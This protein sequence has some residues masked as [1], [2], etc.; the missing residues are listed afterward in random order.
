MEDVFDIAGRPPSGWMHA[1]F[2]GGPY[3]DDVGRCI[4]GPPAPEVLKVPLPEGGEHVYRLWNVGSWLDPNDPIAVYNLDVPP[5][6]PGLLTGQE[7]IW[8]REAQ[9]QRGEDP[10]RLVAM[11]SRGNM[12]KRPTESAIDT[13]LA[14]LRRGG[15]EHMVLQ[16]LDDEIQG[17]WYIQVLLCDDST[18]ELEYRAGTESEHY[19]SRTASQDEVRGALLGWARTS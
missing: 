18:Y 8:L 13:M 5:A 6:P 15:N 17:D 4:P 14:G 2:H 16:R 19:Q 3:G 10:V 7:R 9:I 1:I 11:N 12:V